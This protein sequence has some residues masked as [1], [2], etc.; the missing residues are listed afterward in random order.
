MDFYLLGTGRMSRFLAQRLAQTSHR[1]RGVYGRNTEAAEALAHILS[2]PVI[3]RVEDFTRS[4][5]ACLLAVSDDAIAPLAQQLPR[6]EGTVVH[7]S[8]TISIDTLIPHPH[9]AVCWP[10]YSIGEDIFPETQIPAGGERN[11]EVAQKTLD[12]LAE[13][14]TFRLFQAPEAARKKLHLSAVFG[15][16]FTNHLLCICHEICREANLPTEIIHPLLK[17]T[18]ERVISGNPCDMQTGP[19]RRGDFAT[20]AKHLGLLAEHPEWQRVYEAISES[21]AQRYRP[22]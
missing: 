18:F 21:I 9:R 22:Q 3:E 17:Q 13:A 4:V 16:N 1:C 14:L 5:D 2:A 8:G 15:N 11:D 7:F 19:A 10:V 12:V 6:Q 20:Q